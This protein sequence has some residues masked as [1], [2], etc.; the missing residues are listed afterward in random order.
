MKIKL[1]L[2]LFV[3]PGVFFSPSTNAQQND[4]IEVFGG[5]AYTGYSVFGLYSG[6]WQRSGFN[7]WE[8]SAAIKLVPHLGAEFDF[9][10][11]SSSP[12]GHSYSLRTYMA[13]PRISADFHGVS[14]YGHALFGALTFNG[15][16]SY[17]DGDASFATALGGG[18]DYWIS[19]HIGVRLIQADYLRNNNT[20]AAQTGTGRT[21]PG[22][23]FR[24]ATGAVFRVGR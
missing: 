23:N 5:Y 15:A 6:P 17:A 4:R 1:V 14:V 18:V 19:R 20:A 7:G 13:G 2:G 21:G 11:G 3:L 9:G 24:I 16:A 22:N 12:F 8:A 10:G